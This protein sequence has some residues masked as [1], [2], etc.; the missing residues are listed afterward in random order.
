MP[1]TASDTLFQRT[2]PEESLRRLKANGTLNADGSVNAA[3]AHRL[4][5]DLRPG[6]N[7]PSSLESATAALAR[8]P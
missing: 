2:L 7:G 6:W 5:W 8:R 1:E 4:G 3:T